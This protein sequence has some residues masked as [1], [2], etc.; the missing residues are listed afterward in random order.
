MY[1]VSDPNTIEV[2]A[3]SA[4]LTLSVIEHHREHRRHRNS[5]TT[6]SKAAESKALDSSE[7]QAPPV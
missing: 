5:H 7:P 6:S 4:V 3:S 1:A 2:R